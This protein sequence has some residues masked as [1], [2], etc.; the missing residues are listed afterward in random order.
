MTHLM[1]KAFKLLDNLIFNVRHFIQFF[2]SQNENKIGLLLKPLHLWM[3]Q[4]ENVNPSLLLHKG[5][6]REE[7]FARQLRTFRQS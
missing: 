5:A 7:N 2:Y 4:G 3:W 6:V 1:S